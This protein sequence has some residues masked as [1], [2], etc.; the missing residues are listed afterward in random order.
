M[1]VL[2]YSKSFCA[3]RAPDRESTEYGAVRSSGVWVFTPYTA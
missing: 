2:E 3:K 1:D